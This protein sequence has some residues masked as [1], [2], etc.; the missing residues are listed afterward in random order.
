MRPI[1]NPFAENPDFHCFACSP[2]NP[3]GLGLNFYE[4]GERVCALWRPSWLYE[5]YRGIIHGGI[6]GTILDEV[7]SWAV[8][9]KLHTSGVT[10]QMFT[11]YL[12]PLRTEEDS[13]VAKAEVVSVDGRVAT[14]RAVLENPE[15]EVF[16][17]SE[18]KYHLFDREAA[19][20]HYG[21]PKD[22][23]IFLKNEGL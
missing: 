3:I 17:E 6:Q 9:V 18:V 21:F 8:N 23:K 1:N 19:Q 11:R 4:D 20:K 13:V 22:E 14:L 15:G 5:G 10:V 16:T 7:A 12:K 2:N